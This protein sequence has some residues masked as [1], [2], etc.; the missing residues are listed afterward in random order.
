MLRR[1]LVVVTAVTVAASASADLSACGDKFVRAGRSQRTK[2]Y[3]SLHPASILIYKPD[4]TAK[5]LK[6]FES[7]LK[8]AGHKPTALQ[9]SAALAQTLASAKYDLVIADY[10]DLQ[11]VRTG[12]SSASG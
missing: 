5:G 4:A 3:A 11:F 8:K 12:F 7:L 1:L 6:A 9:D 2:G 10:K